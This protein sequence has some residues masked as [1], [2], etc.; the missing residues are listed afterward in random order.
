MCQRLIGKYQIRRHLFFPRNHQPKRAKLLKQNLILF[1]KRD[2][3][4]RFALLLLLLFYRL[5]HS[6]G[7]FGHLHDNCRSPAKQFFGVLRQLYNT[8]LVIR[9]GQ[10]LIQKQIRA[11]SAP[12]SENRATF[13]LRSA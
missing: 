1:G 5:R 13:P 11:A 8:V 12:E 6:L 10:I 7:L 4:R 2:L 3:G 9:N